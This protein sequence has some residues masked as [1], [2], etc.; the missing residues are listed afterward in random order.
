MKIKFKVFSNFLTSD[1]CAAY[2]AY[3]II[4]EADDGSRSVVE[5][6]STEKEA[7]E[8][9]VRLFEA[10]GLEPVHLFDAVYDAVADGKL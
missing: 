6:V 1:D 2:T 3:G 9:L 4:A 8:R 5:D 7:D 10:E